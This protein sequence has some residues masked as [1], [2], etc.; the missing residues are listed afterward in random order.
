MNAN[1]VARGGVIASWLELLRDEAAL[2]LQPGPHHKKL[3]G[4]AH[5]LHRPD[6]IDRDALSDFPEQAD[7]ALARAVEALLDEPSDP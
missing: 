2:L 5:A 3:L 1:D 6:L 4:G 7:G